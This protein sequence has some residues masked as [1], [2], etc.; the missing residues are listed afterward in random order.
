MPKIRFY[1]IVII[2]FILFLLGLHTSYGLDDG[3]GSARKIEGVH[4][5]IYY[6]PRL[7]I[8]ALAQQ[9]NISSADRILVGKSS[10]SPSSET[11]LAEMVDILFSRACDILDM[12]LYSF[13]G[14]IKI[15]QD[16]DQL[17]RVYTGLFNEDLKGMLSFY[18]YSLN[19]IYISAESFKRGMLGHE[20]AHAIISHYFVVEAPIKIQEV[21][22]GYVEY[23][24][25]KTGQ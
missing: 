4:F 20:I 22:A 19:T 12:H 21:L 1:N 23:Q 6:S 15:C 10:E 9:L 2:F 25:R 24:L 17:N 8:I 16:Y 13:K 18:V 7:D 14:N 11:G 3:F 5:T